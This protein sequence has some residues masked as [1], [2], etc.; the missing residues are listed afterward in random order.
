MQS[1]TEVYSLPRGRLATW[2]TAPGQDAPH[3]IRVALVGTLFGTLPIFFGGVF[4]TIAVAWV[5]EARHPTAMFRFWLIAE[6]LVCT[7]RLIVLVISRRRALQ[8]RPT[9][10]DLYIT[11]APLWGATVGY[12]AFVS[13][14]SGDWVAAT[15]SFLSAAAMVGG[16]CF[17]NFAAPR[18]VAAMIVLSL[19]PCA[20]G[21]LLSGEY[22][23]LLTLVQIPFYL[24]AMSGAARRLNALLIS[25]MKAERENSHRARHDMLTGLLNR[26]GLFNA[27]NGDT[28]AR[29]RA[30]MTLLYLDLDGFKP[31][32]D[33]YGHEA[34]DRLLVQV[35]E[36][37]L[38]LAGSEALVARMGGDEFVVVGDCRDSATARELANAIA[39]EI[40]R[41]FDL[42]P[43]ISVHVGASVG[44]APVS[45][46]DTDIDAL[47][48]IADAAMYDAKR[49]KKGDLPPAQAVA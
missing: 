42:A 26:A 21:A 48:R 47:L 14:I 25:T 37:L 24:F 23:L 15:L 46:E 41:P 28:R 18:L 34:G 16:I 20:I 36:R 43:G 2:L 44:I 19:G 39:R 30:G 4:N 29:I 22:V 32:N 12:G 6:I 40:A 13:A 5:L 17:R 27:A 38:R 3:E 35:A 8:H 1:R 11:L 31:I 9:P 33:A 7:V 45:S 49:N 10:T